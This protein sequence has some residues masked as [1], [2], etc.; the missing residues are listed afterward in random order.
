MR[1]RAALQ[2]WL[3]VPLAL[4]LLLSAC[5]GGDD[6]SSGGDG[7][8]ASQ[9]VAAEAQSAD[10]SEGQA[11]ADEPASEDDE[12]E[13][14]DAPAPSGDYERDLTNI[15]DEVEQRL[16]DAADEFQRAFLGNL[17]GVDLDDEAAL[18]EALAGALGDFVP[19]IVSIVDGTLAELARLDPPDRFEDDHN[20]FIAGLRGITRLQQEGLDAALEADFDFET[21]FDDLNAASD[22]LEAE[23][24]REL[25]AE[26][27]ALVASFFADD[28]D[29]DDSSLADLVGDE[30]V[31][32][33]Q[34]DSS[35]TVGGQLPDDFPEALILPGA[36]LDSTLAS[37]EDGVRMAI[38]FWETEQEPSEVLDFYEEAL[39]EAGYAGEQ[40]R[41]DLPG[42]NSLSVPGVDGEP[43]VSIIATGENGTTTVILSLVG[44]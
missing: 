15:V 20:R 33:R 42:F 28:D 2:H 27:N 14:Q 37:E 22:A 5:S 39:V 7:D 38:T 8:Q 16:D 18:N 4:A 3:L 1:I 11:D 10:Q 41:I 44:F 25:S 40:D 19:R 23:L 17:D 31:T 9:A 32:L 21:G 30:N 6:D 26:F 12:E 36:T 35:I 43:I 13:G 34:G 29:E 24:E